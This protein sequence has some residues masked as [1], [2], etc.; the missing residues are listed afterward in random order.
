MIRAASSSSSSAVTLRPGTRSPAVVNTTFVSPSE[1]STREI[2]LRKAAFG[3][4]TSTPWRSIRLRWV[5]SRYATR[6]SA[7]TVLPVPG[8][9]SITSTPG[10]SSRMIRSCSAWIVATMSRIP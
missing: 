2:W 4:T 8:P 3:P 5:Y 1:G 9:P 10:W 7:T 6:C